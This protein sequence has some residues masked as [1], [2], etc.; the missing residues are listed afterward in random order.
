[1]IEPTGLVASTTYLIDGN[2]PHLLV[3]KFSHNYPALCTLLTCDPT[4]TEIFVS[5][6]D[7]TTPAGM[8]STLADTGSQWKISVLSANTNTVGSYNFELRASYNG[9]FYKWA[10][11]GTMTLNVA[12][13]PASTTL[14]LGSYPSGY[15]DS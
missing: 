5:Q 12:C 3:N 14:S 1:M 13:G 6:T 4:A 7:L 10:S 11:I 8:D 9:P 2:L 15:G